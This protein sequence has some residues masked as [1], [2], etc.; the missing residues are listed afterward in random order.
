MLWLRPD[1]RAGSLLKIKTLVLG[2]VKANDLCSMNKENTK[3]KSKS[4]FVLFRLNL[5]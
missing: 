4:L 2:I 1:V 5:F 3:A